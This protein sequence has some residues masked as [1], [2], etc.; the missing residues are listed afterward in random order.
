MR[1]AGRRRSCAVPDAASSLGTLGSV[2]LEELGATV[3]AVSVILLSWAS[4]DTPFQPYVL[5]TVPCAVG[6]LRARLEELNG[7][8]TSWFVSGGFQGK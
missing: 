2:H 3:G 7:P 5:S 1:L 4:E 6:T 8:V